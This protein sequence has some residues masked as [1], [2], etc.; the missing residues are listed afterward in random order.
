MK[1]Q[2]E[3]CRRWAAVAAVLTIFLAAAGYA[4]ARAGDWRQA[5]AAELQSVLPA[6]APV[7]TERIETDMHSASGITD[8]HGKYI[9]DVVLITA[10]YSAEGKYS[11]F[12][13]TQVPLELGGSMRLTPGDYVIGYQRADDGV[14]VHFYDAATGHPA[15][16]VTAERIRTGYRVESF[17]IWP[18]AEHSYIQIGRFRIAYRI[19]G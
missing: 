17:R 18:P 2:R 4:Q 15:G 16:S 19:G 3:L 11:H 13:L 10:G 14:V 9:A 6:R 8:G 12:F 1:R 7:V 5:T